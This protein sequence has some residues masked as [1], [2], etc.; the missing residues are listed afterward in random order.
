MFAEKGKQATI[1]ASTYSIFSVVAVFNIIIIDQLLKDMF[2]FTSEK[3][4]KIR[5][6]FSFF[7]FPLVLCLLSFFFN[8]LF[9][10][11][12]HYSSSDTNS[13][14][15]GSVTHQRLS[16]VL[17]RHTVIQAAVMFLYKM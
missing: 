4:T 16:L 10:S 2:G 15:V 9:G 13:P 17:Q 7:F 14:A 12:Q 5:V 8:E 1:R 3:F 11:K 6:F